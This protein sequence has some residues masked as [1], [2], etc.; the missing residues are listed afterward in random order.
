MYRAQLCIR[1]HVSIAEILHNLNVCPEVLISLKTTFV[2]CGFAEYKTSE[3]PVAAGWSQTSLWSIF[4]WQLALERLMNT[5]WSI[6]DQLR[7]SSYLHSLNRQKWYFDIWELH[8]PELI[9]ASTGS[10]F[11]FGLWGLWPWKVKVEAFPL[12]VSSVSPSVKRVNPPRP[13]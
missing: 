8:G 3:R 2:F 12:K 10:S 5:S 1:F 4:G 13:S 11:S 6:T 7:D 9:I